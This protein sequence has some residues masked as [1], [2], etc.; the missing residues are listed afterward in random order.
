MSIKILFPTLA[1]A[2]ALQFGGGA[3]A[4]PAPEPTQVSVRVSVADLDLHRRP[5]A[6]IAQR[7][8][9]RAA[10]VVCGD[11]PL[12][13]GLRRHGLFRDCVRAT[14]LSALASPGVQ[15]AGDPDRRPSSIETI[16]A[17]NR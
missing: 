15:F 17:A 10:V 2:S 8:I 16:L 5:G 9:H 11:E 1:L 4:A 6:D 3:Q 12:S 13:S 14:E 7:R